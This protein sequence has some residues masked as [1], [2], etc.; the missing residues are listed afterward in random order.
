MPSPQVAAVAVMALLAAGVVLGSVTNPLAQGAGASAI[1]LEEMGGTAPSGS[2]R[3]SRGSAGTGRRSADRR[4]APEAPLEAP[5]EEE[6]PAA[7][8][9]PAANPVPFDP[10]EGEEPLPEIK[11][12]FLIVLEG[13]GYEEAFGKESPAPYLSETLAGEGKLLPN[14]YAVAQGGLANEIAL[15]S[16]QG[17]TPQT[18]LN[19]PES[20]PVAPGTVSVE[21]Q[22]EGEGCVYPAET[23]TLPGQLDRSETD[24]EGLRRTRTGRRL[25]Q[26]VRLLR[27]A[28]RRPRSRAAR[29]RA[30]T[31]RHGSQGSEDHA[32]LLLHRAQRLPRR[33]RNVVR[34]G[35]AGWPRRR[36]GLSRNRR[37]R[38]HRLARLPGRR[39]PDRDHLRPGAPDRARNRTPAPAARRRNT[40]TC[41]RPR[42]RPP[43]RPRAGRSNRAVVAARW[44]CC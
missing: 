35:T 1:I 6:A 4:A 14:Y 37:A 21:G 27:G 8:P 44:G 33:Q 39:R 11:H 19:C 36:P 43:N 31:A 40:R 2:R 42:R 12:V 3:T 5:L 23:K 10:E 28:R 26:A 25:A 34:P 41:R 30:R 32:V 15:L 17:P 18:T 29:R 7:E 9:A 22:V 24:L 13:H 20:T 38:D 16:G